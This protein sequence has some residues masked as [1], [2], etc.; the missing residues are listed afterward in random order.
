MNVKIKLDEGAKMPV[1]ANPDD[2]CFDIYAT[3][4]EDLGDGRVVYGT[5]LHLHP[6]GQTQVDIRPR[7]SIHKT[8]MVLSNS[9]G[10]GDKGYTGEYKAVFYDVIKDLPNYEVGDRIAQIQVTY[11]HDINWV[12]VDELD[13][14][15]R[16]DG[17]FGSTG[18]K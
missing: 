9:I 12:V 15:I 13:E 14:T 10:T 5:G 17:G 16:G 11:F 6:D 8:G 18:V 4:K 7:S 2:A 3:S 1:K